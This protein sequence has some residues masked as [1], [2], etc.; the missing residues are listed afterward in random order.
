MNII[1]VLLG[2]CVLNCKYEE[3]LGL[4]EVLYAYSIKRHKLGRYYLVTDAKSLQLVMNFSNTSKSKPQG[5][6]L[7]LDIWGSEND[8]VLREFR[9]NADPDSGM[10]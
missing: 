8:L 9:V 2:G 6:V 10:V 5:N 1:R 4:E 7:L 3:R